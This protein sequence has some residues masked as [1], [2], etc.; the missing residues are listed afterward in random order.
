VVIG[1]ERIGTLPDGGDELYS[2]LFTPDQCQALEP[3]LGL[4]RGAL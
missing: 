3:A 4:A 2:A 1:S